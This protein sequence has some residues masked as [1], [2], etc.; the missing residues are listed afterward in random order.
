[1]RTAPLLLTVCLCATTALAGSDDARA[2]TEKNVEGLKK[3]AQQEA[4]SSSPEGCKELLAESRAACGE[5][6]TRGLKVNCVMMTTALE[7]AADQAK[8]QLFKTGD[9]DKNVQAANASCRVHLRSVRSA[10]EK[11]KDLPA[12]TKAPAACQKLATA[13]DS[14]CFGDLEKT[15]T[16]N[17]GCRHVI[18]MTMSPAL[19]TQCDQLLETMAQ[20]NGRGGARR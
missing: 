18:T 8:G 16:L 2:K 11:G 15:G 17:A 12:A 9:A 13:V 7:V 20:L 4:Q 19:A 6:F 10:R 3:A 14:E 1:M 5:I